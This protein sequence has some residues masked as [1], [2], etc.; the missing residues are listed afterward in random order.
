MSTNPVSASASNSDD[1]H[2]KYVVL[3]EHTLCYRIPQTPLTLGVL[4]GSVIRGGHNPVNGSISVL[5]SEKLR[6]ATVEDFD[7]FH[8][9]HIGHLT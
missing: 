5:P 1:A 9:C 6:P 2:T 4:A 8:V 7:F 3:G